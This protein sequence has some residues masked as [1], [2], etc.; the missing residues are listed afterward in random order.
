MNICLGLIEM[1][2]FAEQTPVLSIGIF[3]FLSFDIPPYPSSV[4]AS[5][6]LSRL[7]LGPF[8]PFLLLSFAPSCRFS[9]LPSFIPFFVS[10][11]FLLIIPSFIYFTPSY[12]HPFFLPSCLPSFFQYSY[13]DYNFVTIDATV[14]L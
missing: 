4:L 1:L 2:N 12:C 6:S 8:P 3:N 14:F 10:R 5:H 9:F 7:F 13:C 11:F